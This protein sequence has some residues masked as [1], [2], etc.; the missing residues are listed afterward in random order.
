VEGEQQ[1]RGFRC[2]R[3]RDAGRHDGPLRVGEHGLDL[4][5]QRRR[6]LGHADDVTQEGALADSGLLWAA[7]SAARR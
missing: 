5:G 6:H 4:L 7:F 1:H 2:S 3:R